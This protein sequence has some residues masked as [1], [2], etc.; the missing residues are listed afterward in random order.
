M[1]PVLWVVIYL[2]LGAVALWA[3]YKSSACLLQ[4]RIDRNQRIVSGIGS[5]LGRPRVFVRP[6]ESAA[7][8]SARS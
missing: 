4:A 3:C 8:D 2:L 5:L 1:A 7:K 6:H